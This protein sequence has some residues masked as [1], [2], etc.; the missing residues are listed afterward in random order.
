VLELS[1]ASRCKIVIF[2]PKASD[3]NVESAYAR[4]S[5]QASH[6]GLYIPQNVVEMT[7]LLPLWADRTNLTAVRY[8]GVGSTPSKRKHCVRPLIQRQVIIHHTHA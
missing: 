5:E 3:D 1:S 6:T 2:A 4:A 8:D 7:D